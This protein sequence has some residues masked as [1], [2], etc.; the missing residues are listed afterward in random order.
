M[1]ENILSKKTNK[2]L[3]YIGDELLVYA[4]RNLYD[5]GDITIEQYAESLRRLNNS[6]SLRDNQKTA[7]KSITSSQQARP[8]PVGFNYLNF[9][10]WN[11]YST[12]SGTNTPHVQN[13]K[14]DRLQSPKSDSKT[15]KLSELFN[16]LGVDYA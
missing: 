16:Y 7:K 9:L 6:S 5:N 11:D 4:L 10:A 12:F 3:I 13:Q 8:M 1:Q 2:E 15:E 14:A